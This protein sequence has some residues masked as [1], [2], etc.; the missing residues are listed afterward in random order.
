VVQSSGNKDEGLRARHIETHGDHTP[1]KN[2]K[3]FTT[4]R[5]SKPVNAQ[6][7]KIDFG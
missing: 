7:F 1:A 2:E 6:R 5:M 4:P 3:R